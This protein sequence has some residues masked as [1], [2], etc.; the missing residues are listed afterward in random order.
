MWNFKNMHFLKIL[1]LKNIKP[2]NFISITEDIKNL[3][4][5]FPLILQM[6]MKYSFCFHLKE[7]TTQGSKIQGPSK[8]RYL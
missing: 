3:E 5:N 2:N 4:C 7:H 1:C 8:Q 6:S